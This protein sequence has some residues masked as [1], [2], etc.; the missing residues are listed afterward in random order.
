MLYLSLHPNAFEVT[1]YLNPITQPKNNTISVRIS[2]T[3]INKFF[4]FF[5]IFWENAAYLLFY[6]LYVHSAHPAIG[7]L[8]LQFK[9]ARIIR[10]A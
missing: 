6:V 2:Q 8:P 3:K 4:I 7:F 5:G 9:A 10:A 1:L